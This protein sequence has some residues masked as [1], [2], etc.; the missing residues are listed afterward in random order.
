MDATTEIPQ[1][2]IDHA[3][4]TRIERF[5]YQEAALLDQRDYASW[6]KILT[7]DIHYRVTAK[8]VREA[9]MSNLEFSLMDETAVEFKQRVDQISTPRL[10]HAENPPSTTR[11]FVSNVMAHYGS[12]SNEFQV[13]SNLLVYRTTADAV[14]GSLY[15]G[16]RDDTLRDVDGRFRLVNRVVHLDQAVMFGAIS[17]LF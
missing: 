15:S 13:T 1:P 11:R 5:L 17:I 6:W 8:V 10:T 16:A 2:V 14:E 4:L 3:L 12:A 7:E 9:S